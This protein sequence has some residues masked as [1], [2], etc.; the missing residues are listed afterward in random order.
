MNKKAIVNFLFSFSLILSTTT[1]F[2]K[3]NMKNKNKP[4]ENYLLYVNEIVNSF[5]KEMNDKYGF[6]CIGTGGGMPYDV[7][8]IFVKFQVYK[9]V[10]IEQARKLEIMATKR[11][12]ELVNNHKKIRPFLREYP[13]GTDRC[14]VFLSFSK[15]NN[16]YYTDGSIAYVFQARGDLHYYSTKTDY[17]DTKNIFSEPF[18]KAKEI[19]EKEMNLEKNNYNSIKKL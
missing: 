8:E 3:D 6:I 15:N 11:L 17:N 4:K 7:E 9:Q 14:Q 19:V 18:E 12:Q 13:F 16:N 1:I 10:N 5:E 2:A